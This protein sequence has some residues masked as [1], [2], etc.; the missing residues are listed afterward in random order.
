MLLHL[1]IFPKCREKHALHECPLDDIKIC[2][3]CVGSHTTKGYP[4]LPGLK[5]VYQGENQ[6][7]EQFYYAAPRRPWK[8]HQSGMFQDLN[9]HYAQQSQSN[10]KTPLP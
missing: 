5:V 9:S 8:T 4:S 7:L 10:W 3:S 2:E 1:Y 6:T